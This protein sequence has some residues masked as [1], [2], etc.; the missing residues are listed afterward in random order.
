[1]LFHIW[2]RAN[3][4]ALLCS[5]REEGVEAKS[6]TRDGAPDR[7]FLFI[8]ASV[9]EHNIIRII[10]GKILLQFIAAWRHALISSPACYLSC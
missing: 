8:G 1:M 6:M 2:Q 7:S 9:E 5:F 3:A 4:S 10:L